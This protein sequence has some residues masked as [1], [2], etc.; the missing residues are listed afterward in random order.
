MLFEFNGCACIVGGCVIRGIL[1]LGY[2]AQPPTQLDVAMGSASLVSIQITLVIVGSE[3][4]LLVVGHNTATAFEFSDL[5]HQ[6]M[7]LN[8]NI[9]TYYTTK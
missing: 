4:M 1:T 2:G 8:S 3:K 6:R 7:R 9:T 5:C